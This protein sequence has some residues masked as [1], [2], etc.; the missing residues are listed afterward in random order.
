MALTARLSFEEIKDTYNV[1][2][3]DYEFFVNTKKPDGKTENYFPNTEARGGYI[4]FTI[5]SP[6]DE[7]IDL[8]DW[9]IDQTEQSGKFNFNIIV[10]GEKKE[11]EVIFQK[12]RCIE[13]EEQFES[14]KEEQ[15]TLT[16]KFCAKHIHFGKD[17]DFFHNNVKAEEKKELEASFKTM[18]EKANKLTINL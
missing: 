18:T 13:L 6:V 7:K 8:Y 9:L 17:A 11:K 5:L 1:L 16:I 2:N 15:M 12:A 4:T 3:C 10:E 14:Q